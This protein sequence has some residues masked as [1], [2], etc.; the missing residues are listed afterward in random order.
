MLSAYIL[1][2]PLLSAVVLYIIVKSFVSE[3]RQARKDGEKIV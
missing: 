3:L 1:V 2:W